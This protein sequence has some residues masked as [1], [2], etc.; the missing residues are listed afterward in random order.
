MSD[1]QMSDYLGALQMDA[2][3]L[4]DMLEAICVLDDEKAAPSAV[5]PLLAVARDIALAMNVQLDT[6]SRPGKG[7]AA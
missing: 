6:V 7:G 4:C 1:D 3:R 2:A 5:T